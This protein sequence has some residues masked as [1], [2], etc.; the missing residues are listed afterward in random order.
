MPMWSFAQTNMA[1]ATPTTA[2]K[3]SFYSKDYEVYYKT[4]DDVTKIAQNFMA[5]ICMV[6]TTQYGDIVSHF[7]MPYQSPNHGCLNL[8]VTGDVIIHAWNN[9]TGIEFKNMNYTLNNDNSKCTKSGDL[10]SLYNC[11]SCRISIANLK[12]AVDNYT[13]TIAKKYG[14]YIAKINSPEGYKLYA[15]DYGPKGHF[16]Y[17]APKETKG[18]KG[19]KGK[20]IAKPSAN[21]PMMKANN[22]IQNKSK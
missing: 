9:K 21:R 17:A 14:T 13:G 3:K 7:S 16:E 2:A 12:A 18:A 10:N 22:T 8:T 20:Q 6:G 5:S 19:A 4:K 11:S 1:P 15:Y